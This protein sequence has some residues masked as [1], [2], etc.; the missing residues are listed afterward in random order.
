MPGQAV[1]KGCGLCRGRAVWGSA[2]IGWFGAKRAVCGAVWGVVGARCFG[3]GQGKI[4]A[5]LGNV[6]AHHFRA[7]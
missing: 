3:I 7:G 6:V 1:G 4:G 2:G 5:N